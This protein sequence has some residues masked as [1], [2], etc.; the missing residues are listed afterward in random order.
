MQGRFHFRETFS[1]LGMQKISMISWDVASESSTVGTCGF[2]RSGAH[3]GYHHGT[4]A[5]H[6][7]EHVCC[8]NWSM[9]LIWNFTRLHIQTLNVYMI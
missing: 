5:H 9:L 2:D 7:T 1:S 4:P 6:S 8:F 3:T